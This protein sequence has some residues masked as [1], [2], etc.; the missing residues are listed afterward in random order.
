MKPIRNNQTSNTSLEILK[1][2]FKK[3]S[4]QKS[5]DL[6]QMFVIS[7]KETIP[8]GMDLKNYRKSMDLYSFWFPSLDKRRK[9]S[10]HINPGI[11]MC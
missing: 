8:Q 3:S 7:K 4:N 10:T 11:S 5:P 2:F 6:C 9:I 1:I